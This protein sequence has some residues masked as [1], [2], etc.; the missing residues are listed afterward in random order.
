MAGTLHSLALADPSNPAQPRHLSYCEWGNAAN[1][2]VVVCVH[3]L[4]RNASDFD[5]LAEKLAP[6]F[7]VL[8]PDMAGRGK[9]DWLS[10]KTDYNY[11]TYLTDCTA[12]LNTLKLEQI[13]WVGTSMGGIIGMMLAA[14]Q[15]ARIK[16]MV[17]NDVGAIVSAQGLKRI[18]GYVGSS[19][20]FANAGEAMTYLKSVLAPFG[21]TTEPEWQRMLEGSFNILPD[22]SYALAYDPAISQ[23]FKEAATKADNIADVD[24]S[25]AWNAVPCPVL[26]L[27]GAESDILRRETAQ[28]MCQRA[29]P[30]KLVE[31]AGVGHAPAL[32]SDEQTGIIT[33]WLDIQG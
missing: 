22:G 12:L 17:L 2:N 25:V 11:L 18:L 28:A 1:T 33:E 6:R 24:L 32:L 8:C 5:V 3:G 10:N 30:T 21:I 27:R 31:F 9:S 19:S 14:Q 15:P 29:A 16:N 4:S 20:I 23:P 13:T 7:R 26:I